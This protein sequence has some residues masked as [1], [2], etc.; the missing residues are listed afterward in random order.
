MQ[1]STAI[2]ENGLVTGYASLFGE[3]D[4]NG[5]R[6]LPGAFRKGLH[7]RALSDI[8]FLYQHDVA[9][10]IGT[11]LDLFED[12]RGL[13]VFGRLISGV[14][15]ARE[16]FSLIRA[17]ALDGLS[18]GFRT[19]RARSASPRKI[20]EL[21]DIDLWEISLVTFPMLPSA[22]LSVLSTNEAPQSLLQSLHKATLT[23]SA[24]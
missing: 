14:N 2:G 21:I 23:L 24:T 13:R 8:K 10:P 20:R 22:R 9:E 6:V 3:V 11:W 15:R 1:T 17:G 7:Q 19:V 16:C 4:R 18:I 12:D 5:D